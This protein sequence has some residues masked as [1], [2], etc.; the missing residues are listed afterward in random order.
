M[1]ITDLKDNDIKTNSF[2]GELLFVP[3]ANK[4]NSNRMVMLC[5]HI[6]QAPVLANKDGGEFPLVNTRF[7]NQISKYSSGYKISD[8]EYYV[9]KKFNRNKYNYSLLVMDSKNNHHIL[10]RNECYWLTEKYG[11]KNNNYIDE[12]SEGDTIPKDTVLHTNT[13]YDQDM[14]LCYGR[15][16]RAVFFAYKDLTHE[17]AIVICESAAKK[18]TYNSVSKCVVN[19]NTNDILLNL[20]GDDENY[21]PFPNIGEE[22]ND[23]TLL[24]RRR[25]VYDRLL[26]D[27]RNL[28]EIQQGDDVFYLKGKVIDIKVYCNEDVDKLRDL[29][30]YNQIVNYIDGDIEYHTEIINNL[31][32]T[33]EGNT[34][35]CSN[36]LIMFYNESKKRMDA[37]NYFTYQANK[38]DNIIIEFTIMEE[39]PVKKG[40]KMTGRYG[41]KGVISLI[42]PDEEMPIIQEGPLKGLRAEIILNPLGIIGRMNPGQDFEQEINFMGLFV[43][44][45]MKRQTL[46]EN[47]EELLEFYRYVAPHQVPFTEKFFNEAEE[48]ELKEFFKEIID[49]GIPV[50]QGP[51]FDNIDIYKLKDAYI[52]YIDKFDLKP[53]K[54]KGVYNRLVMGEMY[55]MR[56]KHE[57]SNKSS[58]RSTNFNDLKDLPA[59][60]KQFKEFKSLYPRTPIKWGEMEVS[61]SLICK[62]VHAVKELMSS[63]ATN[64]I[65][66]EILERELLTGNPFN[67][68][69][70]LSDTQSKTSE[71]LEELLYCLGIEL[72]K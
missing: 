39:K 33:V 42:L 68:D 59:K 6:A 22:I 57:P 51:Y 28:K 62:N 48:D 60:D 37:D 36:D 41:N 30:Y 2:L 29:P 32:E 5:S 8:D 17:D 67:I 50:H 1:K 63:Y 3:N 43:R 72:E 25:I 23:Q 13:S 11:Y 47:K 35:S 20:Y 54:F 58:I 46:E 38:F 49:K 9:L 24:A 31:K 64:P 21:K 4:C 56:L 55:F 70:E 65:D 71:I 14:N 15:N 10:G 44:E 69:F 7:E 52:H 34:D 18:M 12:Y 45:A 53:F 16:L 61:N 26:V 27:L 66:R 40:I 19:V